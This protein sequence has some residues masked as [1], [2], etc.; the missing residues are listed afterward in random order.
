[1][2][3]LARPNQGIFEG[4]GLNLLGFL[5][6]NG[7]VSFKTD[8]SVTSSSCNLMNKAPVVRTKYNHQ[9]R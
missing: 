5:I 2:D 4:L 3:E 7:C 6:G 1:M 8:V 9:A